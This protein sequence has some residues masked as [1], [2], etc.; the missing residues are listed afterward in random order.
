[1][2]TNIQS[3]CILA[4]LSKWVALSNYR[5]QIPMSTNRHS[6]ITLVLQEAGKPLF[7]PDLTCSVNLKSGRNHAESII[8]RDLVTL[9]LKGVVSAK[10]WGGQKL[11]SL[12]EQGKTQEV[13]FVPSTSGQTQKLPQEQR[14]S[15]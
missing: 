6:W 15:M 2:L 14:A 8:D 4:M 10:V 1:M 11:V 9:S 3:F 5:E 12:T 7:L 13:R